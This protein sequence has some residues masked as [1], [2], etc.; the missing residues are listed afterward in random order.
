MRI[1]PEYDYIVENDFLSDEYVGTCKQFPSLSYL[2]SG[3]E[4]ASIGIRKL[5]ADCVADMKENGEDLPS[6]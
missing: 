6:K 3:F 1:Y 5:V 4:S 2:A